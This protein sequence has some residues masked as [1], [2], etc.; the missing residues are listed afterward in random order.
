MVLPVHVEVELHCADQQTQHLQDLFSKFIICDVVGLRNAFGWHRLGHFFRDERFQ[1]VATIL[2]LFDFFVD[3]TD[4]ALAGTPI[5]TTLL[6]DK[7]LKFVLATAEWSR[8]G[9]WLRLRRRF[10]ERDGGHRVGTG[11]ASAGLEE[12]LIEGVVSLPVGPVDS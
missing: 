5:I 8:L 9:H 10:F 7:E 1:E 2:Q 4:F 12:S 6:F 3:P 11:L